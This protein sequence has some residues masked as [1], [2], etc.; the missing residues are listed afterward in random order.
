MS[1]GH[2]RLFEL[3]S[4]VLFGLL[5]LLASLRVELELKHTCAI[6]LLVFCL[7][8]LVVVF[9]VHVHAL[10]LAQPDHRLALDGLEYVLD[11]AH[12]ASLGQLAL[13]NHDFGLGAFVGLVDQGG[14]RAALHAYVLSILVLF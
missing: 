4:L 13:V 5:W 8:P 9:D 11:A 12:M 2:N 7:A 1:I 3:T 6:D 10:V 14:E